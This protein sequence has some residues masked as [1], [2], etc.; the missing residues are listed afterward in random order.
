MREQHG[1]HTL[2]L[3]A[4]P[5]SVIPFDADDQRPVPAWAD[6][7]ELRVHAFADGARRTVVI[8][9]TNGPG[10]TARFE[11]R[12]EGDRLSVTTDSPHPWRLRTGGPDGT[13][14]TN[15]SGP[16]TTEFR[17]EG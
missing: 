7:V 1:F 10:E 5:D 17:Y 8:P 9:S 11:V 13:L 15:A 14:H 4:R 2:P 3:L 16:A 12:R 6:D